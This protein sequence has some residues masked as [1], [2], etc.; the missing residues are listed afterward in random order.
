MKNFAQVEEMVWAEYIDAY[1]K[2]ETDLDWGDYF[3]SAIGSLN[4]MMENER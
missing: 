2:G 4:D 3:D 1:E